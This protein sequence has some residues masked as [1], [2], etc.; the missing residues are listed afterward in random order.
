VKSNQTYPSDHRLKTSAGT[1]KNQT[2][3][4]GQVVTMTNGQTA[5]VTEVQGP[6][7]KGNL[8]A[9]LA[10]ISRAKTNKTTLSI[11]GGTS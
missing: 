1:A 6:D 5:K 8:T 4:S 7:C 3:F 9:I 10:I 11:L 2:I